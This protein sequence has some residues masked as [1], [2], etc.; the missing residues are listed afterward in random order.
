M[1]QRWC[2]HALT[3][4]CPGTEAGILSFIE[5]PRSHLNFSTVIPPQFLIVTNQNGKNIMKISTNVEEMFNKF[6][7]PIPNRK[8]LSQLWVQAEHPK[9]DARHPCK[10][11][12]H[13]PVNVILVLGSQRQASPSRTDWL[14]FRPGLWEILFQKQWCMSEVQHPR[15]FSGL[16]THI[17]T[18]TCIPHPPP[19]HQLRQLI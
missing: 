2:V 15:L 6:P 11:E 18:H 9:I 14:S 3:V 19:S 1:Y 16:H 5:F 10:H 17:H 4:V 13:W 7:Y 8:S 12:A